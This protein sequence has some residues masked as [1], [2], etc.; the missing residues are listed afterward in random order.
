MSLTGTWDIAA[1][2]EVVEGAVQSSAGREQLLRGLEQ[3]EPPDEARVID[4]SD[5]LQEAAQ[6]LEALGGSNADQ[7]DV[8]AMLL[9]S[10][11][12]LHELQGDSDCPICGQDAALHGDWVQE[13]GR[14]L[15]RLRSAAATIRTAK[16]ALE[17][18]RLRVHALVTSPPEILADVAQHV[19][20]VDVS[21]LN[22]AWTTWGAP[23][24]RDEE[25]A[26]H[27][28]SG[29]GTV[30]QATSRV[31]EHAQR[32]RQQLESAWRPIADRLLELL[33]LL[34]EAQTAIESLPNIKKAEQWLKDCEAAIRDERFEAIGGEVKSIWNKIAEGSNVTLEEVKL[35]A[36]R[37]PGK[38]QVKMTVTV[39]G[40]QSEAL[41]VM[42]QGEL[43]ALALSLFVPRVSSDETPFGFVLIDD[44]VQSMD[45]MRV[46]Q[47]AMILDQLAKKRQVVVFTHDDRLPAAARRRNVPADVIRVT[48]RDKSRVELT[49][50]SDAAS[51]A[52][53]DAKALMRDEAVP[54]DVARRVVP[55]LCR[56]ALEA[57]GRDAA[58]RHMLDSGKSFEECEVAWTKAETFKQK[59]ALTLCG[60]HRHT[61]RVLDELGLRFDPEAV[62]TVTACNQ[63]THTGAS[64]NVDLANL[65]NGTQTLSASLKT[66][67]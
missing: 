28:V 47:L 56:Q 63:M 67:V 20:E 25:L 60:D 50:H 29:Y 5:T 39:D 54:T 33:P 21:E 27:L 57:S 10:A 49:P 42:S 24:N 2:K 15:E 12:S 59:L 61:Y 17:A 64:E 65:I 53:D 58:W 13:A 36:V 32:L 48:R 31:R 44:P 6:K 9:Q 66:L 26:D 34:E 23:P 62:D 30:E 11:I 35:A 55:G 19:P 1:V 41:G 16:A 22:A 38:G 52:V 51:N 40:D 45:P 8:L 46:D 37:G 4:D 7:A 3:L 18:A 14:E 43:M